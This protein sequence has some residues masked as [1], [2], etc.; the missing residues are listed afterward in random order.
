MVGLLIVRVNV[1][2]H[3]YSYTYFKLKKAKKDLFVEIFKV[4]VPGLEPGRPYGSTDF[5]SVVSTNSTIPAYQIVSN[6]RLWFLVWW[7]FALRTEQGQTHSLDAYPLELLL[8]FTIG[9]Y[10]RLSLPITQTNLRY[11]NALDPGQ[12]FEHYHNEPSF[13]LR[14]RRDC[15]TLASYSVSQFLTIW[16]CQSFCFS[17]FSLKNHFKWWSS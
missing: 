13:A 4:P 15:T 3:Y 14:A 16:V 1:I 5:K 11:S 8:V 9:R 2:Y 10:L 7:P 17:L 6:L 12:G